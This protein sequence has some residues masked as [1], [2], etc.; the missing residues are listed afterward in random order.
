MEHVKE[1][2]TTEVV[3]VTQSR[4]PQLPSFFS[5]QMHFTNLA[6]MLSW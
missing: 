2:L 1:I 4:S 6:H 5:L 3:G